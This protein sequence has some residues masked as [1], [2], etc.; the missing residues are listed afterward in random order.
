MGFGV[1]PAAIE[2]DILMVVR[3]VPHD[4]SS[5]TSSSSSSITFDLANTTDRFERAT[6]SSDIKDPASVELL[7]EGPTRWANYFKVAWKVD[8]TA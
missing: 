3:V 8:A 5:S 2:L 6:F 1:L 4:S 7:H